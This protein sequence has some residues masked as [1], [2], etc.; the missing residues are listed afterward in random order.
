MFSYNTAQNNQGGAVYVNNNSHVLWSG[1]TTFTNNSAGNEKGGAVSLYNYSTAS[2]NSETTFTRNIATA[3][4]AVYIFDNCIANFNGKTTFDANTANPYEGGALSIIYSNVYLG[5]KATFLGNTA[6]TLGGAVSVMA[7]I[8]TSDRGSPFVLARSTVFV[9]NTCGVNGGA[10]SLIGGVLVKLETNEIIFSGNRAAIAGGA[11][12]M[13]G[14][15]LGP[16]YI[17]VKFFSNFASHGGAVYSTGSGN[18][19]VGLDSKLRSNP[20]VFIGCS[21]VD[22]QAIATGGA[23]HSAAG[24]DLVINT[25]FRGNTATDGGALNLAGTSSLVNCSFVE[26]ISDEGRGPVVANIGYMSGISNCSF[27]SNTFSCQRGDFLGYHLVSW[28]LK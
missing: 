20:V 24:Q 1:N 23:I 4:G 7:E 14:N 11:I 8:S 9:N 3:G 28:I 2:W 18:A 17:G 26:N 27:H 15:D 22:N 6:T 5:D 13:W 21:F 19:L 12:S 25:T 10:L 16:F